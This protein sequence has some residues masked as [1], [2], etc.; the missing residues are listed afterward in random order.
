MAKHNDPEKGS[1]S[2]VLAG[3]ARESTTKRRFSPSIKNR[4]EP[5]DRGS[6]RGR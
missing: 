6:R 4:R 5:Y 3:M 2:A 1:E